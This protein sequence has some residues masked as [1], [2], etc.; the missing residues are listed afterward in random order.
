MRPWRSCTSARII[1][2]LDGAPRMPDETTIL[3]FRHLL[4]KQKL[5]LQVL[6]IINHGL[7]R[8]GL[9]LKTGTVVDASSAATR[10]RG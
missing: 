5:A 6:A 4:E 8:Q 2:W 3:R 1:A 7:A 9:M 10:L